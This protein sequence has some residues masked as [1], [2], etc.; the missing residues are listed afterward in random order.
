MTFDVNISTS[1]RSY[2][3]DDDLNLYIIARKDIG[4]YEIDVSISVIISS[5]IV[6]SHL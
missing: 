1:I 6:S 3:K 5:K 4:F 2:I